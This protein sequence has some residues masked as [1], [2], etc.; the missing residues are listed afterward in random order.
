[1]LLCRQICFSVGRVTPHLF[2]EVTLLLR[3]TALGL[4]VGRGRGSG[5]GRVASGALVR[6]GGLMFVID[7]LTLF[8]EKFG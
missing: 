6:A 4:L 8:F 7:F 5:G 1:M 2:R 3:R